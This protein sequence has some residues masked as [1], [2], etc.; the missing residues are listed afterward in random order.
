ME[1]LLFPRESGQFVAEQS[2]DVFVEEEGVRKVAQMLYALRGSDELSAS[3]WKMANPLAPAPTS[4][5]GSQ[6]H[7]LHLVL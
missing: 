3:G 6:H 2:Q 5:Q 1:P 4:D 7:R